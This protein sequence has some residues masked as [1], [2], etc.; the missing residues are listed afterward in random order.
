M[1]GLA[2]KAYQFPR[3][4]TVQ[5]STSARADPLD[6]IIAVTKERLRK[7]HNFVVSL[8]WSE[9]KVDKMNLHEVWSLGRILGSKPL[10]LVN[11]GSEEEYLHWDDRTTRA[12]WLS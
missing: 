5:G 7:K 9:W 10:L 1:I 12:W 8:L 3:T 2:P 11:V 6:L 4:C